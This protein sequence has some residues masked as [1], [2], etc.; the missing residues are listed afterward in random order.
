MRSP[1]GEFAEY[2]TSADN[3]DFVQ[4]EA[5]ADSLSKCRDVIDI[6][7]HNRCYINLKPKCEPQLGRRGLYGTIGG[8]THTKDREMA[9][10]WVLNLSDG[11]NSLLDIAERSGI[12]FSV[13]ADAA[14]ALINKE[15]IKEVQG[16]SDLCHPDG[17]RSAEDVSPGHTL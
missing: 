15:L 2:H 13:I 3:L 16:K 6:L 7:E 10:L 17:S 11:S 5:L 12:T 9:M 8:S 4:A 1:H 14:N